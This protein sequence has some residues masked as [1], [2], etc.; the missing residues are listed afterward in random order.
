MTLQGIVAKEGVGE[1]A[2]EA[3]FR[4]RL[5]TNGREGSRMRWRHISSSPIDIE[6]M[7]ARL[8]R[9]FLMAQNTLRTKRATKEADA[10]ELWESSFRVTRRVHGRRVR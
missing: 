10:R 2:T 8:R 4:S 1:T 9:L 6:R 3:Y 5:F 7:P